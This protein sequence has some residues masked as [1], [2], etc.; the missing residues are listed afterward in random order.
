MDVAPEAWIAL[1]VKQSYFARF[2]MITDQF[3]HTTE[4]LQSRSPAKH[5]LALLVVD[6]LAESLLIRHAELVF[7]TEDSTVSKRRRYTQTERE[8]IDRRFASKVEI[9]KLD[10]LKPHWPQVGA[11]LDEHD[12][13]MFLAGHAYR[14][15]VRHQDAHNPVAIPIIA[16]MYAAAVGRAFVRSTPARVG[17]SPEPGIQALERFGYMPDGWFDKGETMFWPRKAAETVVSFL[18]PAIAQDRTTAAEALSEDLLARSELAKGLLDSLRDDGLPDAEIASMVRWHDFWE[19]NQGDP[20]LVRLAEI[21]SEAMSDTKPWD[22]E[23][24][25]YYRSVDE[26][27]GRRLAELHDAFEPTVDID[28]FPDIEGLVRRLTKAQTDSALAGRYRDLDRKL[29]VL[30]ETVEATAISW[31]RHVDQLVDEARGE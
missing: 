21:L 23:T 30:E 22:E 3:E 10:A 14:N 13:S 4:L 5:R 28:S 1:N 26:A 16:R 25:A 31:D 15:A 6:S 18:M 29:L 11:V 17:S 9:G 27:Q 24:A 7:A 8:K 20:E 2:M 12:A 19:Q